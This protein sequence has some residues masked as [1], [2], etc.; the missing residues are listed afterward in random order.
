MLESTEPVAEF[1]ATVENIVAWAAPVLEYA[2]L[3]AAVWM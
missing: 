1:E 3:A 2:P